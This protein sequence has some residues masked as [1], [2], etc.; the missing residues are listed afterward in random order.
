METKSEAFNSV[1]RYSID[2]F[3]NEIQQIIFS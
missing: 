2:I 1:F 3:A